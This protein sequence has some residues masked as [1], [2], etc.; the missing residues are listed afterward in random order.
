MAKKSSS[1][2]QNRKKAKYTSPKLISYGKLASLT[3]GG[4]LNG[5]EGMGVGN[6]NKKF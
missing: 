1:T 6:M 2:P 5:P 3:L 4:S